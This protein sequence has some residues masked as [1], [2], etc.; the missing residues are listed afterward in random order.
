MTALPL[1]PP[2]ID[3]IAPA[4]VAA[5]GVLT[6]A[7]RNFVGD[8]VADTLVSFDS[9]PG[10]APSTIQGNCVRVAVPAALQAGTR[11]VRIVRNVVYPAA[12]TPHAGF[13]SSPARFQLIPTIANAPPITVAR[14]SSLTLQLLPSV[15]QTQQATL[16]VGD[17]ALPINERPV[18]APTTSATLDFPI[19]ANFPT[20]TFPLR[21]EI[22]GAS[23][24]LTLDTTQGSPTQGQLLPQVQVT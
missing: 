24:P 16:Y 22:D 4:M 2:V 23:S 9:A 19:P 15:G 18:G 3:Q 17:N 7:G 13:A 10:V 5:G 8:S 6:I 21:L 12:P 1:Q 20:G 11:S 14:G